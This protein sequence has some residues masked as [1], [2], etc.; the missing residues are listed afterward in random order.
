MHIQNFPNISA[1][2]L[3]IVKSFIYE[4]A[5]TLKKYSLVK[6]FDASLLSFLAFEF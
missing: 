2:Q 3:Y 5:K 4:V 6:V 1:L